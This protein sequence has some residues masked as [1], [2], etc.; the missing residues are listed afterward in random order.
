RLPAA[1]RSVQGGRRS[2]ERVG[3]R[4]LAPGRPEGPGDRLAVAGW[5]AAVAAGCFWAGILVAGA[6][7][8]P[9]GASS[10]LLLVGLGGLAA[11]AS[12]RGSGVRWRRAA[13][14]AA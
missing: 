5:G 10:A 12:R 13:L 8:V 11:S 1:A 9:S 14:A 3:D 2:A 4:P 7:G 6:S